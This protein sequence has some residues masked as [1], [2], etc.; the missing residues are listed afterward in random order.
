MVPRVP[1]VPWV[2][3]VPIVGLDKLRS[4]FAYYSIPLVSG[5]SPIMLSSCP[6]IPSIILNFFHPSISTSE[7]S[8]H[9]TDKSALHTP[10]GNTGSN[11]CTLQQAVRPHPQ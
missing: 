3:R 10:H 7:T 2:P 4:L 1:M 8:L 6:I 9:I 5:F 11:K